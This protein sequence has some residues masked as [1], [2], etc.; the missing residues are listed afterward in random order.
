MQFPVAEI[1]S[2]L[3]AV[4]AVEIALGWQRG[5]GGDAPLRW[6]MVAAEKFHTTLMRASVAEPFFGGCMSE[7]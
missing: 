1:V 6:S 4:T 5:C 2:V 3:V 7:R